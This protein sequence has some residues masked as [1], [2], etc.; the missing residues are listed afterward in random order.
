MLFYLLNKFD[1]LLIYNKNCSA[2]EIFKFS[3]QP[4]SQ[5]LSTGGSVTLNCIATGRQYITYSWYKLVENF[6]KPAQDED[7]F[8]GQTVSSLVVSASDVDKTD[9]RRM[10]Q[11][12]AT[13]SSNEVLLSNV[14]TVQYLI[15]GSFLSFM[16]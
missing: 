16:Q 8:A 11:C 5:S 14:A 1:H 3:S 6:K 15:P 13:S 9:D 12:K 4:T 10:F 2:P 7:L